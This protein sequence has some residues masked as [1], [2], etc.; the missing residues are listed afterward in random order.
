[1]NR[2]GMHSGLNQYKKIGVQ[3][4]VESASPHR[5]IQML[6][7]GALDKIFAAKGFMERGEV[8]NKG[9]YI[10]W[11]I[12]IIDG[13]RVS[14]DKNL[15]NDIVKN[16]DALYEYMNACLL[17]ANVKNDPAKLDEVAGLMHEIK[18][19]WDGIEDETQQKTVTE[20]ARV[21]VGV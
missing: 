7:E 1:M 8:A 12:S 18:T 16:L 4:S 10:S 15:D 21:R 20:Q 14:L 5:L 13:L 11:A 19:G 17:E 3:G 2:S 6:M 9:E